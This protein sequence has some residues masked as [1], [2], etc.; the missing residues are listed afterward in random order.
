MDDISDNKEE[1]IKSEFKKC[2]EIQKTDGDIIHIRHKITN[3]TWLFGK[4]SNIL[5]LNSCKKNFYIM[6]SKIR[7]F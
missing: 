7:H 2:F 4:K 1:R 5:S 3:M 6:F